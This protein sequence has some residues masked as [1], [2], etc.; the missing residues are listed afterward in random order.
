MNKEV[1]FLLIIQS[2]IILYGKEE[3]SRES[4][5]AMGAKVKKHGQ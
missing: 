4:F 5:N 1:K 2:S 3:P